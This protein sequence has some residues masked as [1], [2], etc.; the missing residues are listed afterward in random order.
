MFPLFL[1]FMEIFSAF[2]PLSTLNLLSEQTD[3]D[4]LQPFAEES[5]FLL[6]LQ[7]KFLSRE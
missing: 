7:D 5:D 3:N 1:D 4:Y 2:T 6:K